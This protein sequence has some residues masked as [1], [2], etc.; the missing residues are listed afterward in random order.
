[1]PIYVAFTTIVPALLIFIFDRVNIKDIVK[2]YKNCN[3][4]LLYTVGLSWGIMVILN[5]Y[6]YQLGK[7]S[8]IAPLC[9]LTAILNVIVG[10]IFLKEKSRLPQKIIAGILIVI[11]IILIKL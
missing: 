1:M 10:Y 4:M 2:E 7:V 11:S 8:V 9:S 6:A 5:L 3:K